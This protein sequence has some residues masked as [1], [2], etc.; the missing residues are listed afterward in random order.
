MTG[1][2]RDSVCFYASLWAEFGSGWDKLQDVPF[3]LAVCVGS[4]WG[5]AGCG[6]TEHRSSVL[7]LPLSALL[8]ASPTSILAPAGQN[9]GQDFMW[10]YGGGDPPRHGSVFRVAGQDCGSVQEQE[11]CNLGENKAQGKFGN[12]STKVSV[13]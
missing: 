3:G 6:R 7:F 11:S 13:L 10:T 2:V 1:R 8:P 12:R 9:G 4:V 5:N